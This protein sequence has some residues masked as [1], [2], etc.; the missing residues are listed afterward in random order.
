MIPFAVSNTI[1]GP[2]PGE[3]CRAD[4][5]TAITSKV[6]S[7]NADFMMVPSLRLDA[8]LQC[9]APG[10]FPHLRDA[11]SRTHIGEDATSTQGGDGAADVLPPRHEGQIDE[12]PPFAIDG[13]IQRVVGLIRR[14]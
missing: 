14:A 2:A 1:T 13:R 12:R 8:A 3:V 4:S 9:R 5:V 11:E 7:A 10:A 6:P